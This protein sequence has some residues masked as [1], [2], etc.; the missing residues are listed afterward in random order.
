MTN[1]FS[2]LGPGQDPRSRR[3]ELL[4]KNQQAVSHRHGDA[5]EDRNRHR[6]IRSRQCED[7][8]VVEWVEATCWVY[9]GPGTVDIC[10]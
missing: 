1:F 3:F 6:R 4:D 8:D 2:R 5:A 7:A 10:E 9:S